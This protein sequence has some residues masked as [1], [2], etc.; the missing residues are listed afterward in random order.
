[1]LDPIRELTLFSSSV[2]YAR[3]DN[4][5]LASRVEA[6]REMLKQARPSMGP[7]VWRPI[8]EEAQA[9]GHEVLD[10]CKPTAAP[11]PTP[12]APSA[13]P[14]SP[15]QVPDALVDL[16]PALTALE[17]VLANTQNEWGF[18]LKM[19]NDKYQEVIERDALPKMAIDISEN[20]ETEQ[21]HFRYSEESMTKFEGFVRALAHQWM[22]HNEKLLISRLNEHA[23][24]PLKALQDVGKPLSLVGINLKVPLG[25]AVPLRD[26]RV[27]A[28]GKLG[29]FTNAYREA[30]VIGAAAGIVTRPLMALGGV[31]ALGSVFSVLPSMFI[32]FLNAGKVQKRDLARSLTDAQINLEQQLKQTVFRRL[33]LFREGLQVRV[34]SVLRSLSS[35]VRALRSTQRPVLPAAQPALQLP[36]AGTPV[37]PAAHR[38]PLSP[39][40]VENLSQQWLPAIKQRLGEMSPALQISRVA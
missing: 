40:T 13:T 12:Q 20:Q 21:V 8:Y 7:D 18:T 5:A 14:V 15:I 3:F 36:R 31:G 23:A 10:A 27:P 1:M 30:M 29:A 28:V 35:D 22:T 26:V 16:N 32:G 4:A 9:L 2:G 39:Q 17:S 33:D 37:A 34:S 11:P 24:D 38:P 6:F 25:R 19:Q